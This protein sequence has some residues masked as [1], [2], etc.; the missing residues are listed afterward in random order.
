MSGRV[1][2]PIENGKGEVV[3]YAG[4]SIDGTGPKYRLPTGFKKS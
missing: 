2:I 4:R 1:V 3:A